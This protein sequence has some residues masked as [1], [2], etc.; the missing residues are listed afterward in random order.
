[1]NW[2]FYLEIICVIYRLPSISC[3]DPRVS[4]GPQCHK[5][6]SRTKLESGIN[7]PP[8]TFGTYPDEYFGLRTKVVPSLYN[9]KRSGEF[10]YELKL[11]LSIL[12]MTDSSDR[13][14][15]MGLWMG[16]MLESHCSGYEN[17]HFSGPKQTAMV[18]CVYSFVRVCPGDLWLP[19]SL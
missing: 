18:N 13:E 8:E 19:L 2:R 4:L 6:W 14:S 17:H 16:K 9:S 10:S 7:G 3:S 5:M 12:L 1:M 11:I 15:E